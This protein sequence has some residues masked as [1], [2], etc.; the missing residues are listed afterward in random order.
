MSGDGPD[1]YLNFFDAK[2][3][4]EELLRRLHITNVQYLP[5]DAPL[6]HPGRVAVVRAGE[7][8]LGVV[9]ELHPS[10][11]EEWELGELPVAAWDLSIEAL[12]QATPERVLY[13]QVSPYAPITQDMAFVMP[14]D[15]AAGLVAD[16]IQKAAG[17]VV[18][19]V[20]LFD[21][22]TGKPIP[23]GYKSLAFSVTF[24]DPEK[25]LTEEDVA[26]LRKRI[27]GRLE[28][29]LGIKLRT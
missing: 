3:V 9:G 8:D 18:K 4:V 14:E 22:Y 12:T 29:E 15:M 19:S 17:P 25:P 10:V 1:A 24:S 5:A 16:L 11:I 27:E 21:I 26:K 13:Q 2:G 20:Y 28:R 7:V 23:E 6:F